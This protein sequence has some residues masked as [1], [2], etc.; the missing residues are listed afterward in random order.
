M[1]GFRPQGP[2]RALAKIAG[3]DDR[4]SAAKLRGFFVAVARGD[5]PEIPPDEFYW[6]DLVGMSVVGRGGAELGT[7]V[8]LI[9]TGAHDILRVRPESATGDVSENESGKESGGKGVGEILI[10]FVAECAPEVDFAAG[11]IFA[12]WEAEW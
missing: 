3:T 4:E 1:T 6:R 11:K 7:V 9:R 2:G 12:E 10:P 8:G 5:L